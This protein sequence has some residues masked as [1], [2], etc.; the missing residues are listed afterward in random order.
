MGSSALDEEVP[1]AAHLAEEVL[2]ETDF[3]DTERIRDILGQRRIAMEQ[4]FA[5]AGHSAAMA[6]SPPTTCRPGWC[7]RRSPASVSTAS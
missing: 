3:S 5:S 1:W 6:R 2:R 7:A 4:A